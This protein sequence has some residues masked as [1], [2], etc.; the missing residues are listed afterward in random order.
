MDIS[1]ALTFNRLKNDVAELEKIK[2][3]ERRIEQA[4]C[5]GLTELDMSDWQIV[6][7]IAPEKRGSFSLQSLVWTN[8][9]NRLTVYQ[10]VL[11][12]SLI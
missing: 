8:N 10:I 11:V 4:R 3:L 2:T 5:E 7:E 9:N 1:K 6:Y 12:I